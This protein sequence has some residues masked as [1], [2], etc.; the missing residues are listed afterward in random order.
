M[1]RRLWLSA[2]AL[3]LVTLPAAA[4]RRAVTPGAPGHCITGRVAT[5]AFPL[6]MAADAQHVYWVDDFT[7]SLRRVPRLGGAVQ[8]LA[9]LEDWIPFAMAVDE[10]NV[11]IGAVPVEAVFTV[12]P[13]GILRVPKGG[14][15][16][17]THIFGVK[18]PFEVRVDATHLY[19]A[20]V[21]TLDF[22]E[23]TLA[24]DG[25]IER[26][27]K[28]GSNRQ[29]LAEDLSGPLG[30]ALDGDTVYFGETGI[31][32]DDPTVGLYSVPKSGGAVRTVRGDVAAAKVAVSGNSV[33]ILGG[34][35]DFLSGLLLVPKD[36]SSIRTL[37]EDDS[38]LGAPQVAD[39]R[40]YY[41]TETDLANALWSI[42][43]TGGNPTLVR[44]NLYYTD[45][46]LIDGCVVVAGTEEGE[47]VRV[48]R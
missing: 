40:V 47:L 38:I 30:L 25:K 6:L 22:V 36:G 19:W 17:S 41:V 18:T 3:L 46:F 10:T 4:K 44:D 45:A 27:L 23:E 28:N 14:G 15:V 48:V 12:A 29:T 31:A 8:E 39:N 5:E 20:D 37:R 43:L 7:A 9:S 2:L 13:G 1:T 11:Y 32:D 16:V 34:T 26:A 35:D 21:G 24:S 42:P 33:V